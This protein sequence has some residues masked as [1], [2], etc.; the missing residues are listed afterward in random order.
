RNPLLQILLGEAC[1][2]QSEFGRALNHF[3]TAVALNPNSA[4]ANFGLGYTLQLLGQSGP[5]KDAL[6]VALRLD[7]DLP[8][9]N[10][11][12]GHLLSEEGEWEQA[13]AFLKKFA[14]R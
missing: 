7:P 3:R 11:A 1:W 12:F 10:L 8:L 13:V 4:R 9:A 2:R 6:A 14:Q 5:A